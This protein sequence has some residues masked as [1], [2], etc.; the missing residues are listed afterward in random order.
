MELKQIKEKI[1]TVR[2]GMVFKIKELVPKGWT[3]QIRF[4]IRIKE[5]KINPNTYYSKVVYEAVINVLEDLRADK[6]LSVPIGPGYSYRFNL[7]PENM[8]VICDLDTAGV[9][10]FETRFLLIVDCFMKGKNHMT[11]G[12]LVEENESNRRFKVPSAPIADVPMVDEPPAKVLV[13]EVEAVKSEDPPREVVEEKKPH[14]EP[15]VE[16]MTPELEQVKA[17][18]SREYKEIVAGTNKKYAT[19]Q[20]LIDKI[21]SQTQEADCKPDVMKL[22]N[23][24]KTAARKDWKMREMAGDFGLSEEEYENLRAEVGNLK[25]GSN[26]G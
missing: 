2:P 14:Q 19:L 25:V 26:K 1:S 8:R 5:E 10:I 20:D 13:T 23:K 11:P 21:D 6:S 22:V 9:D 18:L 12:M 4:A 15:E 17:D 24:F 16:A 7:S 3:G